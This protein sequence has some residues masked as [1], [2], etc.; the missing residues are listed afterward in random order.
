[1]TTLEDRLLATPAAP[2]FIELTQLDTGLACWVR[3]DL[4]EAITDRKDG[5][6]VWLIGAASH[7]VDVTEIGEVIERRVGRCY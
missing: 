3:V 2:R 4:I 7:Y 6:R 1:M 5:T